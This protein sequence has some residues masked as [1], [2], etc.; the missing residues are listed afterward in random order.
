MN[1]RLIQPE[2]IQNLVYL[3]YR[4]RKEGLIDQLDVNNCV[5]LGYRMF[6]IQV[7]KTLIAKKFSLK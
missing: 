3:H 7:F 2:I 4:K 1:D 6:Y 5:N